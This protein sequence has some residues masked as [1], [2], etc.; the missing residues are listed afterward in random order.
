MV[1]VVLLLV[2]CHDLLVAFSEVEVVVQN[3]CH[4]LVEAA[5]LVLDLEVV[6]A[7]TT[8]AHR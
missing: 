1:E 2:K 8:Y 3:R 5:G 4:G 6:A 7:L